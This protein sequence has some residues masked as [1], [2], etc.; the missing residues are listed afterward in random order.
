MT[1]LH[2]LISAVL[3][4][5]PLLPAVAAAQSRP[6]IWYDEARQAVGV[7]PHSEGWPLPP[8]DVDFD[9]EHGS[10]A[11][12]R[13]EAVDPALGL[14]TEPGLF[15][16][17]PLYCPG[18]GWSAT[19]TLYGWGEP[20]GSASAVRDYR[21]D[22]THLDFMPGFTLASTD[23]FRYSADAWSVADGPTALYL[24]PLDAGLP[25]PVTRSLAEQTWYRVGA[26][27]PWLPLP[28][29][30]PTA[31]PV[32]GALKI[33]PRTL[34]MKSRGQWVTVRLQLP[35]GSR[36]EAV[37][38]DSLRLALQSDQRDGEG[39]LQQSVRHESGPLA[40]SHD[41]GLMVKFNRLELQAIL[42]PGDATLT[43]SGAFLDGTRLEATGTLRVID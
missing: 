1:A 35:E 23:A 22:V 34:S 16:T 30:G 17:R 40:V 24:T 27:S 7:D 29:A 38:V 43:L 8:I 26:G 37:D 32:A 39:A 42:F 25:V 14:T 31:P 5:L 13:R 10:A 36:V 9:G 41:G 12:V 20:L 4:C 11:T 2:R 15:D 3:A 18:I 21:S 28:L 33:S 19:L 6:L